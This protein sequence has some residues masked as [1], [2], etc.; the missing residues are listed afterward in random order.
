MGFL[1]FGI[2]HKTAAVDVRERVAFAPETVETALHE[3]LDQAGL[4]DLLAKKF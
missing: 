3:V 4:K 2:N 1:A